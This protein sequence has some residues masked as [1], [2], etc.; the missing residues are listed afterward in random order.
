MTATVS[1]GASNSF[2]VLGAEP[3]QQLYD[4][5]AIW[6]PRSVIEHDSVS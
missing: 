4:D 6:P 3:L 5:D 2:E 1:F